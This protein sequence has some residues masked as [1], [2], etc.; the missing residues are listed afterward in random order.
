MYIITGGILVMIAVVFLAPKKQNNT[1]EK[2]SAPL[3]EMD[4]IILKEFGADLPPEDKECIAYQL[5]RDKAEMRKYGRLL[6]DEERSCSM[7][8][9]ARR[10]RRTGYCRQTL[11]RT[12]RMDR[13]L[14][15]PARVPPRHHL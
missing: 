15:I 3:D 13:Q 8:A 5:A 9:N 7:M 11:R 1:E 12:Q 2:A 10:G 4:A 14:P 6:T